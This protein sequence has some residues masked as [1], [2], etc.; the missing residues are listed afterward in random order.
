MAEFPSIEPFRRRYSFGDFPMQE[1]IAWSSGRVRY[2][3]GLTPATMTD[4]ELQLEYIMLTQAEA[5]SILNHHAFQNGG[6]VSFTLPSIIWAGH[7]I[8][9]IVPTDCRF[10]YVDKPVKDDKK[11]R[12]VDMSVT[13]RSMAFALV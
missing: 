1:E 3:T 8:E 5:Q 10:R 12:R 11:N 4:L 6:A 13:L 7:S 2:L 9:D